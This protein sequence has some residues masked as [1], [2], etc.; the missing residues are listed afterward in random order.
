MT[1]D[2]HNL[3]QLDPDQTHL[4]EMCQARALHDVLDGREALIRRIPDKE[5]HSRAT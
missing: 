2:T 3:G 1:A 4:A 5:E